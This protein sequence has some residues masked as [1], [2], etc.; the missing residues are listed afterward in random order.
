MSPSD[1]LNVLL[2]ANVN[3]LYY[4]KCVATTL[5]SVASM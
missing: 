5:A 2:D 4:Y 3:G 1:D